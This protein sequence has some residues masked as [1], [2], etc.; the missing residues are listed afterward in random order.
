MRATKN[1]T[2]L[3][4]VMN[5]HKAIARRLPI[6]V[7]YTDPKGQETVRTIEPYEIKQAANGD[8]R[9]MAMCR[10][11]LDIRAFRLDRI[12]HYTVHRGTFQLELPN[13]DELTD[14]WAIKNKNGDELLQVFLNTDGFTYPFARVLG[15]A[16]NESGVVRAT[17][18]GEGGVAIRRLRRRDVKAY[19]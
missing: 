12:T 7:T 1:E 9:V 16:R 13:A 18:K 4:T 14:W 11:R 19:H 15:K 10:L 17:C 6:T 5:I 2:E 8:L 3:D